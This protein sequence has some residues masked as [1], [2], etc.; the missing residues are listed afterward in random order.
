MFQMSDSKLVFRCPVCN[1][2]KCTCGFKSENRL[3]PR[4]FAERYE[5]SCFRCGATGHSG[6]A[7]PCVDQPTRDKI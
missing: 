2:K 5:Q 1:L 3:D 4:A 7:C 6:L